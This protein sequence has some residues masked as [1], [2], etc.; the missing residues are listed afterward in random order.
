MGSNGYPI[1]EPAVKAGVTKRT[2]H[3]YIG[4][5]LLPPAEGEG[6]ASSY[7]EGH[8]YRLL[9]IKRQQEAFLPLDE[10]RRR[11]QSMSDED[12]CQTVKGD[13]DTDMTGH[14]AAAAPTVPLAKAGTTAVSGTRYERVDLGLGL[15][16]HIPL[17]NKRAAAV[18][19]L[20]IEYA[21]K[22]VKEG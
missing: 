3:Y 21:R 6:V 18:A 11:L 8:L 15:E 14:A 10:I 2:I 5:G 20:L 9:Y 7:G 4:R 22:V 12:V 19:E 1:S 17:D 16:L 13:A